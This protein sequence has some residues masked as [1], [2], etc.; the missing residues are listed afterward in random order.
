MI[1]PIE[2]IIANAMK[3]PVAAEYIKRGRRLAKA[4]THG[5]KRKFRTKRLVR[6]E[7]RKAAKLARRKAR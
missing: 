3:C 2:H 7:L 6:D 5:L 4:A 1:V